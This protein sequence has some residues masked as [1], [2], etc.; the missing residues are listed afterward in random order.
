VDKVRAFGTSALRDVLDRDRFLASIAKT[1]GFEVRVISGT[2]EANLIA[3]GVLSNEDLP[4]QSRF[5]L[6]DIGGGSTEISVCSRGQIL[7]SSS[8]QLGTARL[9]QLYLKRSP[10]QASGIAEARNFIKTTLYDE[11]GSNRW[12][13]AKRMLGSS[14][15]IKAIARILTGKE[16]GM[17]KKKE[18]SSLVSRMETMTT[19]ELLGL[20]G[21]ESKRVDMILAGSILLEECMNS[22]K[23]E[24][25]KPTDFSLRDG[26]LQEELNLYFKWGVT[27]VSLHLEDLIDIAVSFGGE[28]AGLKH[29]AGLSQDLFNKTKILHRLKP[30]WQGFL[31]AAVVLKDVGE[32]IASTQIADHSAYIVQNTDLPPM[33][34]W[35]HELLIELCRWSGRTRLEAKA[36]PFA[37][38]PSRRAVFLKLLGLVKVICAL[39]SAPDARI[40]IGR[41]VRNRGS[42]SI[43]FSGRN[44]SGLEIFNLEASATMLRKIFGRDVFLEKG[45]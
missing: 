7:K 9:Q 16:S 26:I 1:T 42:I 21:I 30:E 32:M 40:K 41:V 34:A 25:V 8:F 37:D 2:E 18:L 28:R 38:S 33:D 44:L 11:M 45:K 43:G 27:S 36:L 19:T 31:A 15:S 10:P 35:E 14:G 4:S 6:L 3:L 17:I 12:P 39:D 22:L 29:L 13:G 20:D 5:A 23:T 24:K